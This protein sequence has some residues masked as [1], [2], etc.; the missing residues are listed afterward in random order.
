MDYALDENEKLNILSAHYGDDFYIKKLISNLYEVGILPLYK[1]WIIDNTFKLDLS[2]PACEIIRFENKLEANQQH[3]YSLNQAIDFLNLR[4]VK[5]LLLLDSDIILSTNRNWLNWLNIVTKDYDAVVAMQEGSK[6]LSHPCFMFFGNIDLR[7]LN[8]LDGN[9]SFGFD[10]G[11]LVGY[12]L[13]KEYKVQK[14]LA[15]KPK[16]LPFGYF[17]SENTIFHL[18]SA[19]LAYINSRLDNGLSRAYGI[20]LRKNIYKSILKK[21]KIGIFNLYLL[22]IK[23]AIEVLLNY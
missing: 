23:S 15:V 10:T 5:K 8:F 6:V 21:K 17:Y 7:I 1:L 11:R 22:R 12:Q 3:A 13:A 2:D 18:T 16:W 19:S 20:K 9:K 14:L 4:K